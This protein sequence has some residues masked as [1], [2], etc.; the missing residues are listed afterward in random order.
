MTFE[1]TTRYFQ[2]EEGP[3]MGLLYECEIFAN[4]CLTFVASSDWAGLGWLGLSV[5]SAAV[6]ESAGEVSI[7]GD[8]L[9]KLSF[10]IFL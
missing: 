6:P 1:S 8:P 10:A 2:P 3:S 9:K 7:T 5:C 4:L